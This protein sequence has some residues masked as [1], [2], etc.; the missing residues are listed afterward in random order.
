MQMSTVMEIEAAASK[1]PLE[2]LAQ[3]LQDLQ[4]LATARVALL[5]SEAG[6]KTVSWQDLKRDLDALHG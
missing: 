1:L 5:E 2:D 4:D 3:L 6:E